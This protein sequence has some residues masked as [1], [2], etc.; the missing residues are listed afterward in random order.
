[1]KDSD[2]LNV[3]IKLFKKKSPLRDGCYHWWVHVCIAPN[4]TTLVDWTNFGGMFLF[5]A[6]KTALKQWK[7]RYGI[8][9]CL[10]MSCLLF[11]SCCSGVITNSVLFNLPCVWIL[12]IAWFFFFLRTNILSIPYL[13]DSRTLTVDFVFKLTITSPSLTILHLLLL[14]SLS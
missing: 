3:T 2:K 5:Q 1:M 14:L 12:L 6:T 9:I 10:W 4:I 13:Y 7:M 8:L 11:F